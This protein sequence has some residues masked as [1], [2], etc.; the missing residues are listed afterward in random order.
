[1]PSI[2]ELVHV[3]PWTD[4]K[5][6]WLRLIKGNRAQAPKLTKVKCMDSKLG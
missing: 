2:E 6:A 5:I 1:M 4:R 3:K